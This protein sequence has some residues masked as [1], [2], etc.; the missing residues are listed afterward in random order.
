MNRAWIL[1]TL[2]C[3]VM[4]AAAPGYVRANRLA[5]PAYGLFD[6]DEGTIEV[7]VRMDF[8]PF[9]PGPRYRGH[10]TVFHLG[11]GDPVFPNDRIDGSLHTVAVGARTRTGMDLRWR[12]ILVAGGEDIIHPTVSGFHQ[13]LRK[14]QWVHVAVTWSARKRLLNVYFDGR[15]AGSRHFFTHREYLPSPG[16]DA[17]LTIGSSPDTSAVPRRFALAE[18]RVSSV[19]RR[20]EQLG[21]HAPVREPDRY[22]LLLLLFDDEHALTPAFSALPA[23]ESVS[24]PLPGFARRVEGPDGRGALAFYPEP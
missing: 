13:N 19:A 1:P 7:W 8:E 11:F 16:P 24:V 21:F 12:S 6:T 10:G 18:L 2:L 15:P 9:E 3:A 4:I 23:G 20:P 5:L 17:M 14:H 22:T